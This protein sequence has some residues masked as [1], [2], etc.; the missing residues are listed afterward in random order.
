[1]AAKIKDLRQRIK[2]QQMTRTSDGQG[3]WTESWADFTA[4]ENDGAE[5]WAEIKPMSAS[6]RYFA[7]KIE[8]NTTHK[9]TIRS[10]TGI[11]QEMRI[12]FEDRIFQIN[13]IRRENE[14]R[15]WLLI[16]AK[17]NVAS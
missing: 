2:F 8:M 11:T 7:Q 6:E 14:E 17:E 9:I 1:M 10:I 16:D 5:L 3:G 12:V 4:P 13:G 15:W